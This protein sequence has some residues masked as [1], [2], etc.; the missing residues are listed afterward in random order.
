MSTV[1]LFHKQVAAQTALSFPYRQDQLNPLAANQIQTLTHSKLPP[2]FS[3]CVDMC[4]NV[5]SVEISAHTVTLMRYYCNT[6]RSTD[7]ASICSPSIIENQSGCGHLF[8]QKKRSI[9]S[10]L[11]PCTAKL[12]QQSTVRAS[13]LFLPMHVQ[14]PPHRIRIGFCDI[15]LQST[16][17][18][19]NEL[20]C[21]LAATN[22]MSQKSTNLLPFVRLSRHHTHPTHTHHIFNFAECFPVSLIILSHRLCDRRGAVPEASP[23]L[24]KC[25]NVIDPLRSP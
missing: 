3:A 6:D 25:R 19:E 17:A 7:T 14:A 8:F 15:Y 12:N 21:T 5:P 13:A 24:P 11:C 18:H 2:F 22:S 10:I 4:E 20:I 1:A 9:I 23:V 16:T